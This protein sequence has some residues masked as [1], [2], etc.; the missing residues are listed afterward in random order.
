MGGRVTRLVRGAVHARSGTLAGPAGRLLSRG[1][2]VSGV[3]RGAIGKTGSGLRT[4]QPSAQRWRRCF[5][6]IQVT[7]GEVHVPKV[8]RLGYLAQSRL[9]RQAQAGALDAK[10][11]VW[12]A[13]ARLAYSVINRHRTRPHAM[14]DFFQ[15]AQLGLSRA[16]DRFDLS[17][18]VEFSTYAFPAMRSWVTRHRCEVSFSTTIPVWFL[19]TFLAFREAVVR[20]PSRAAWFDARAIYLDRDRTT[21]RHLCSLATLAEPLTLDAAVDAVSSTPRPIDEL[22]ERDRLAAIRQALGCLDTREQLVIRRRYGL[23]PE[24]IQ[25]LKEIGDQIGLTR[26]RVRQIQ[27]GAEASLRAELARH[28]WDDE[29]RDGSSRPEWADE[30]GDS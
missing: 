5:Y 1:G 11:A 24:R 9:I 12:I 2:P 13:N 23:D 18:L 30:R 3:R 16:I 8:R 28:G 26:E 15:E 21:Y 19:S 17:R 20:A 14:S 10:Q 27:V 29:L 7:Q 6:A 4:A 25:T 22:I